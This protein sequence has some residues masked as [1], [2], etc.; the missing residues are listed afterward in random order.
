MGNFLKVE[1]LFVQS[2]R[3]QK[4]DEMRNRPC[5]FPVILPL[6]PGGKTSRKGDRQVV[7]TRSEA[8]MTKQWMAINLMLLMAAGLL[9]WQL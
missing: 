8:P 3:L 9:G 7:R 6:G 5:G 1:D 2:Y 4:K